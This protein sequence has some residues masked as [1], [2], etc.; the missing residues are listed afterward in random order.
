MLRSRIAA[1][2][3]ACALGAAVVASAAIASQAAPVTR[4]V[5]LNGFTFNGK[6]NSKLAAHV[7]D[8]LRFVWAPSNS[9]AHNIM[10]STAPAGFKKLSEPTLAAHHKPF[11]VKLTRKGVYQFYCVP[12]RPLGMVITVTVS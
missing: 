10:R 6:P 12:H 2:V 8:T 7:G 3:T 9:V 11:L 5:T 1:A 4:T